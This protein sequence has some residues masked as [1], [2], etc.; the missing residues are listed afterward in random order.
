MPCDSR[1]LR[2][3]HDVEPAVDHALAVEGHRLRIHHLGE[4]RDLSCLSVD[5]I[6]MGARLVDDPGE[7]HC[8]AG[9]E[10]DAAWER[11]HFP[12]LTSWRPFPVLQAPWSRHTLAAFSRCCGRPSGFSSGQVRRSHQHMAWESPLF[13]SSIIGRAAAAARSSSSSRSRALRVS[14]A[15]RSNSSRASS[16]RPSLASRSPR[17]LGKQVVVLERRAPTSAHRRARG[18]R[19]D[20]TPSPP[21][22]RDSAPR[23]V[24]ARAGRARRRAPRCAPSRSPLAV[25]AR[26]WQAA[27]AA[28]SA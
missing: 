3:D 21:R 11:R 20:R 14:E 27:I 18:P 25:R 17:T 4:A 6:A 28:C 7:N 5:A 26:A 15:A 13:A 22:P 9:L 12:T 8:F 10:L 1:L 23:P 19:P 16:K 24:T 2:L